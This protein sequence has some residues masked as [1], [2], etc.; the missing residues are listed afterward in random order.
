MPQSPTDE[1]DWDAFMRDTYEASPAAT[2]AWLRCLY[3]MRL[4]VT[5]GRLSWPLSSYARLFGT[6]QDQAKVLI[7]EIRALGIG[8][9]ENLGDGGI[10]LTNRRMYRLFRDAELNRE[11]QSRFRE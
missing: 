4:S 1:F 2:G 6:S 9:A 10:T 5:R 11:R 3:K 7:D 8:D